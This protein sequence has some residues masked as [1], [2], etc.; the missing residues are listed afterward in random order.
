MLADGFFDLSFWQQV[1]STLIGT[2]VAVVLG[3]PTG[4]AI[5]RL[6]TLKAE[7]DEKV[8]LLEALK[9]TVKRNRGLIDQLEKEMK[10]QSLWIPFY[11]FDI[12][13]LEQTAYRKFEVG[14]GRECC[15]SLDHLRYELLHLNRKLDLLR[16]VAEEG[17]PSKRVLSLAHGG[18]PEPIQLRAEG[19]SEA[20]DTYQASIKKHFSEIQKCLDE[21]EKQLGNVIV[22]FPSIYDLEFIPRP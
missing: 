9:S 21:A 19:Y 16:S 15:A 7:A 12:S 8:A 6:K 4:L 13:I 1:G 3:V 20:V 17:L 11:S 10:E 2:F 14:F 22:K 5:D 18:L